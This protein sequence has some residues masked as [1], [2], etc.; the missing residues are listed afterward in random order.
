MPLSYGFCLDEKES[1]YSAA[2]FAQ[3]FHAVVGDGICPYGSLFALGGISGF[4]LTINSGYAL[5]FGHWLKSDE[6]L[7][8]TLPPAGNYEDRYDAIAI[9]VDFT[10]RTVSLVVLAGA[11]PSAPPRDLDRYTIYLYLV[12]VARGETVLEASNITDTR[13][14]LALCGYITPLSEMSGDVEFV[15][16]FLL[17]GID[18]E[19][20]RLIG[21]SEAV[22]Q[23]ANDAIEDLNRKMAAARGVALG[24]TVLSLSRPAP[25]NE[26][27]RCDGSAVPEEYPALNA[28]VGGK[29]PE[30][31]AEDGRYLYWIFAG[32]PA[33]S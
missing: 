11:D 25:A 28:A 7:T 30:M 27:L 6:P 5:C 13:G 8:L 12:R 32:T 22:I 19:V 16:R 10:A 33:H 23:T 17:S 4:T 31:S 3:A 2:Q 14:D 21:L 29:L 24:D 26:W 9:Q 1:T 15:Y 20:A 18:R